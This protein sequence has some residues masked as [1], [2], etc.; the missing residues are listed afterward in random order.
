MANAAVVNWLVLAMAHQQQGQAT[1][2][3]QWLDKATAWFNKATPKQP[4]APVTLSAADWL[5][6]QVLRREA[7]ALVKKKAASNK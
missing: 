2:A 4:G 3:A 1:E 6:A 7:E 5:E